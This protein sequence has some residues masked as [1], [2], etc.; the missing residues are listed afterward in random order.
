MIIRVDRSSP[1]SLYT[2]IRDEIIRGIATGELETGDA[3]PSVR[4][5][6]SDLGI[7]LHTVNKAYALLRDEG[8]IVMQGRRGAFVAGDHDMSA[9]SR[10]KA[11]E[12]KM[13]D[14]LLSLAL[15]HRA[16]NGSYEEFVRYA[17]H[18]AYQAFDGE[19]FN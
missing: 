3:L 8:Y 12:A 18:A 19:S 9:T 5:L 1:D 7:N 15:A 16:R 17:E 4:S 13:Q 14:A 6:A 10:G 11:E 2:Q